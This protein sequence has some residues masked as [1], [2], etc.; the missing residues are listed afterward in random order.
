M[1]ET[2][3]LMDGQKIE[4]SFFHDPTKLMGNFRIIRNDITINGQTYKV[5]ETLLLLLE[6]LEDYMTLA[7]NF[8]VVKA[9]VGVKINELFR[10]YNIETCELI[11]KAKAINYKKIKN[12]NITSRHLALSSLCLKFIL[13][14]MECIG[15]RIE[16]MDASKLMQSIEEHFDIIIKKLNQILIVKANSVKTEINL[17]DT[18]SK[19]TETIVNCAKI[20]LEITSEYYNKDILAKIFTRE[21]QNVYLDAITGLKIG[22]RVEAEA[23]K[24]DVNFYFGELKAL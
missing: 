19:G 22:S 13:Y 16:I 1:F 23:L 2:S 18:P 20:L 24:D 7:Q 17:K 14:I 5:T 9:E 15:K 12:K 6:I 8:P 10:Y 3:V 11:V 4:Q 21:F